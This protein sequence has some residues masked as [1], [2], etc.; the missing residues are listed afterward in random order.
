MKKILILFFAAVC[1]ASCLD[2][3]S[4]MG[5]KYTLG[6]TFQYPSVKFNPDSTFVN[7]KDTIGFGFDALNFYHH[8]DAGLSKA[9]GGFTL[10]CA[11]MPKSGVTEGLFNTYRAMVPTGMDK[12]NIYTVFYQNSDPGKMPEHDVEFS[13]TK[14]GTC[15]MVG[16]YVT[17]TVEVVDYVKQNFVLG[18]RLSLKAVGYLNGQKTGEAEMSLADFSAQKDS[19]VTR[20]TVFDLGKLGMV[21]HVD[22]EITSSN[23]DVPAYFCM[24]SMVAEVTLEY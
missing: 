20:W 12:G 4:G 16:C 15:K 24:D 2:D 10:S 11:E 3:G 8:L 9:E 17:N 6:A 7:Y 22:F 14:F 13:A 23:A 1:A 18:D 19:I 21:E 5:Q